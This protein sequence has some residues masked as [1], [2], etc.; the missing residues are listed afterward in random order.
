MQF[1]AV[2]HC[3]AA[4]AT[5]MHCNLPPLLPPSSLLNPELALTLHKALMMPPPLYHH[6]T[7]CICICHF[8][9]LTSLSPIEWFLSCKCILRQY[10][11]IT[12]LIIFLLTA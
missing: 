10:V 6:L 4:D 7:L 3:T 1:A 11:Q 2:V 5:E 8:F 12:S 9:K